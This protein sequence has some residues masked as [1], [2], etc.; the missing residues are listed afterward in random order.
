MLDFWLPE[1]TAKLYSGNIDFWQPSF[2]GLIN[3]VPGKTIKYDLVASRV[4]WLYDNTDLRSIA[5]DPYNSDTFINILMNDYGWDE[6]SLV[7]MKQNMPSMAP[8]T[9]DA[10]RL[11]L[12]GEL[13]HNRNAVLD[14][15]ISHCTVEEDKCGNEK[16]V[17]PDK[18][19]YRKVDGVVA[20]IMGL[21][22]MLQD[23]DVMSN[24]DGDESLLL[25]DREKQDESNRRRRPT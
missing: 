10:K 3:I 17:K 2:Q 14:W 22:M 1:H 9:A 8:P 13:A 6:D 20:M 16:P 23:E 24:Y 4:N 19:D 5:Y 18:D 11:I 21:A 12:N 25:F 15:Q 7:L